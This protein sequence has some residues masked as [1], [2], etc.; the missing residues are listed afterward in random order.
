[1][2]VTPRRIYNS[3]EATLFEMTEYTIRP[4]TVE[5]KPWIRQLMREHWAAEFIV[6]RGGEYRPAELPGFLAEIGAAKAGLITH[7]IEGDS[8]EIMTLD[9]LSPG[10]GIGGALIEAVRS[11][12]RMAGCRR[13]FVVTTNN[14]LHAL[15]F[16]QRRGFVLSAL[17]PN[18]VAE[19]RK[20]KP[21][22]LLD[23]NGISIRDEIE[24]EMMLT[25]QNTAQQSTEAQY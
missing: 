2:T 12:A 1:M 4:V 24:L 20:H 22:P 7:R 13:L 15:R 19:S 23:E 5:D 6:V 25:P 10:R 8:C 11:A 14:N 21:I 9:S 18:A 17:R 3:P 16:Y